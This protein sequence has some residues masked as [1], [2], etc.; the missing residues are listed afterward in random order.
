VFIAHVGMHDHMH[1]GV[2]LR[3]VVASLVI[4]IRCAQV[5][6]KK[7]FRTNTAAGRDLAETSGSMG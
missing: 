6:V 4:R 7:S 5:A 3:T 2:E 1:I